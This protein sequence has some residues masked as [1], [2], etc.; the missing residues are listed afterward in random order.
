M[1][2]KD[3]PK[4]PNNFGDAASNN[5]NPSNHIKST[6]SITLEVV[7]E[8]VEPFKFIIDHHSSNM[9]LRETYAKE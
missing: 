1:T 6:P 9:I 5:K 2:H 3:N 8:N 7:E 4:N